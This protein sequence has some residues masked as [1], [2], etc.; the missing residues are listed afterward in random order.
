MARRGA[1]YAFPQLGSDLTARQVKTRAGEP[2]TTNSGNPLV[3]L[4]NQAVDLSDPMAVEG[5][6]RNV[7][8]SLRTASP[9]MQ[10]FGAQWYPRVN[11][12]VRKGVRGKGF[13]GSQFDKQLAGAGLVAAVSPNMDWDRRNIDAFAEMKSVDSAGWSKI[14]KGGRGATD[15]YKGMSIASAPLANIQKAG[16]IIA[17]EDPREVL[18]YASAP[19]TH[20]FMQNI[21][22]PDNGQFVTIDG[23]A[24]DTLSNRMIPWGAGRGIS[25]SQTGKNPPARYTQAVG[26]FRDAASMF[27]I[28][29]SAA[30]AISWSNMKYG[31]ERKGGTRRQ[32]PSR[33]GQPYF[34]PE[35]GVP[36]AHSAALYAGH[37][38]RMQQ[39]LSGLG[40]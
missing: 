21:A 28:D 5:A 9:E 16:R 7:I 3:A 8:H 22:Q 10:E 14:M 38:G 24:F 6:K 26:V 23:R 37:R 4:A 29:P 34:D 15:V 19:K 25:G 40:A 33:Y 11:E 31:V 36:S 30:Q 27:D 18:N 35:T 32:G 13:L 2:R 1:Q 39:F 17:G 20:S 12:A